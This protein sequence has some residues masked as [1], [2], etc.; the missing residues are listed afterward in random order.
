MNAH[1]FG[2]T[3]KTKAAKTAK[4]KAAKARTAKAAKTT[5]IAGL[6]VATAL[7]ACPAQAASGTYT[8]FVFDQSS[9]GQPT[10]YSFINSAKSSLDMTM[11]ELVDTTA[12]QDLLNLQAAGVTV[13]VILDQAEQSTNQAAY[14]TLTNGGVSV[15]WSSTDF[16]YTHQKT[17]TVDGSQ[18]MILSGNLT[19]KYYSTGRDYGVTDTDANDVSAI[20]AVFNA[21]FNGTSITPS[22][23]DNLLWSPTDSQSRLLSVINGATTTL[24][25]EQEELS[26][27]PLVNAVVAKAEAGVTVRV[28]VEDPSSWTSAIDKIKNAGG[29]VVGYSGTKGL[30]IHAKA[31]VADYG[32]SDATV[33]VGSMNW[34]SNSL[35]RNRELGII[36][37]DTGV[38]NTIET[39]FGSDYSGGTAQ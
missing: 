8:P 36:L 33:E 6:A 11:Y 25:I 19:S 34:T 18:S 14:D 3:T 4:T 1:T 5:M 23:G 29:S 27:A 31:V 35:T 2:T 38:E 24:D 16:V 9:G 37:N 26:D 32:Q 39:Q 30:Y 13:R 22:D 10:I 17:I 21:D 15:A 12:E 20:E 28:V 7:V